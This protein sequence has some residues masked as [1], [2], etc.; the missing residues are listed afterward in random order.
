[1]TTNRNMMVVLALSLGLTLAYVIVPSL[2]DLKKDYGE[3][4]SLANVLAAV[5]VFVLPGAIGVA[6]A[7]FL[8]GRAADK[9]VQMALALAL[10][11]ATAVVMWGWSSL[12]S[13][14]FRIGMILLAIISAI[15]MSVG[16]VAALLVRRGA[17]AS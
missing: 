5:Y 13:D 15:Y 7:F 4:T 14:A 9:I 1:M 17:V 11:L 12:H 8:V 10:P 2:I 3:F 16:L 6:A